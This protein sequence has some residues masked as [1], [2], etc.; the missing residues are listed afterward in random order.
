MSPRIVAGRRQPSRGAR[1]TPPASGGRGRAMSH[2]LPVPA[3]RGHR[4]ADEGAGVGRPVC[5]VGRTGGARRADR[6]S[7]PVEPRPAP[8]VR[9]NRDEVVS[10]ARVK[11]SPPQRQLDAATDPGRPPARRPAVPD[12]LDGSRRPGRRRRG[13]DDGVDGHQSACLVVRTPVTARRRRGDHPKVA[14]TAQRRARVGTGRRPGRGRPTTVLRQRRSTTGWSAA[15]PSGRGSA[16][17]CA[18]R[19]AA[20]RT[21]T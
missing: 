16:T 9:G 12:P 20:R 8:A 15:C 21:S 17:V 11:P 13:A 5:V 1:R 19:R 6:A 10:A 2:T 7:A 3:G 18:G 4:G 14:T